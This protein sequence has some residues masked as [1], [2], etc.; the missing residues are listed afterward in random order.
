M[1]NT[2]SIPR[3]AALL[4]GLGC[5]LGIAPVA[6]GAVPTQ[7]VHS[8]QDSAMLAKV[9][10]ENEAVL[11]LNPND[12]Q[13]LKTLGIAYHNLSVMG[14]KGVSQKAFANL[15]QVLQRAPEDYEALAY[16]GST[17]TLL[18]RD[19]TN[20]FTKLSQVYKGCKVL[21]GAVAKAPN[22]PVVRLTRAIN[23]LS[24]PDFFNRRDLTREDLFHLLRLHE[25]ATPQ[26]APDV[27]AKVYFNL[28]EY[29]KGKGRSHWGEA[30]KY[31]QK[32]VEADPQGNDAAMA[33]QRLEA[34]K[35]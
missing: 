26:L 25:K 28:G 6:F 10:E 17:Y 22:N 31:W 9:I 29:Y 27:L 32:A 24:L 3:R 33:R 1:R 20:P 5:W 23:S 19:A 35:P 8:L 21:D 13:A 4:I 2:W 16:L 30:D 7:N 15:N 11:K 14:K 12:L 18:G 34:Y